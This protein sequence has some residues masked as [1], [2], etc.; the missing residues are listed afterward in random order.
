MKYDEHFILTCQ[1][2]GISIK[3]KR[4]KRQI[5]IKKMSVLTGI[6]TDY[7]SKIGQGKAYG[8]MIKRHLLKTAN[9]LNLKLCELFDFE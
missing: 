8:V 9:V 7:L 3:S 4:E 2:L 1:K 5:S 6:R